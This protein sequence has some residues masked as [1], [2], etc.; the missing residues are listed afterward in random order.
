ML[1]ITSSPKKLILVPWPPSAG[2]IGTL[3]TRWLR[4][5]DDDGLALE[6]CMPPKILLVEGPAAAY[7]Y[8]LPWSKM[9]PTM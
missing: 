4:E 3:P 2:V 9:S 5:G 7:A 1:L 8:L 6:F